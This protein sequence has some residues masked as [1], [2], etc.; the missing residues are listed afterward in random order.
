MVVI[1]SY[2]HDARPRRAVET[3]LKEGA[4]IDLLCTADER[5]PRREHLPGLEIFRIPIKHRRGGKVAYVYEYLAFIFLSA[6]L[7]FWR[8]LTRRYDLIYVNNMPDILVITALLPKVFGAKVILDQHDPMPEL[9][10]TI[11][12]ARQASVAVR[13]IR[14]LEKISFACADLVIT[15]NIACKRIFASR[16]CRADKIR[17]VMNSPDSCIFPY[18]PAH[19]RPVLATKSPRPFVLMY[20][21]SLVKRNGLQVAVDAMVRVRREIPSAEL[22]IYGAQSQYLSDVLYSAQEQGINDGI[23]YLGPRTLEQLAAEIENCDLG[24]IPNY[25]NS[26]T[27]INTPTRIFE[28]LALGK[29]VVAPR[30]AGIL[31]YFASDS[32]F[33]FEAGNARD[34]ADQILYI[35][36]HPHKAIETAER[37]QQVY[38]SHTWEREQEALLST[39]HEVLGLPGQPAVFSHS[40]SNSF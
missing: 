27:E 35:Y 17:I 10:M 9:M 3:L 7:F 40:N 6:V 31:D 12:N 30:T 28:Y 5:L 32:L 33:F 20:H 39:V 1:S 29:P 21:G 13:I 25:K 24:V 2:P 4:R 26:F 8:S 36:S 23:R 16:S 22:R 15:V 38:L 37:G 14:T 11:F 34:L 18:R 19:S